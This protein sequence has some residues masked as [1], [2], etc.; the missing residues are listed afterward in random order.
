MEERAGNYFMPWL[1]DGS[2]VFTE[3]ST[4]DRLSF[5]KFISLTV[6]ISYLASRCY[7][8]VSNNEC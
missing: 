3:T 5:G 4:S 8:N 7:Q 1:L 2:E 6:M